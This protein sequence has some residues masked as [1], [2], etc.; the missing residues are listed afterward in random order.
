MKRTV[1]PFLLVMLL[2]GSDVLAQNG[3]IIYDQVVKIEIE[4]PPEMESMRDRIP[5]ERSMKRMLLFNETESLMRNAPKD[6]EAEVPVTRRMR[7]GNGTVEIR[8]AGGGANAVERMLL[9]S[10]E[11]GETIEQRDFMGRTFL[12]EGEQKPVPWR[13]TS[14]QGQYKGYLTQKAV[15]TVDSTELIAWF[16]PEIPVPVGPEAYGGLPGAILLLDVD[17]GKTTYT[18]SVIEPETTF[19]D[20]EFERPDKGKKVSQEEYDAV[21]AEKMKELQAQRRGGNRVMF[22]SN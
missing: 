7:G 3:R 5:K 20:G 16:S 12:I 21:V 11:T 9:T 13:L 18:A 14:E 8:M 6:E 22:R 17:G 15:A 2:A 4:L 10:M 1:I 19:A